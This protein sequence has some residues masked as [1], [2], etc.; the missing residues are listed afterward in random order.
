[1]NSVSNRA[2]CIREAAAGFVRHP[3]PERPRLAAR[4]CEARKRRL[5][6]LN[7]GFLDA[8]SSQGSN[9]RQAPES[10]SKLGL[11][12]RK[13]Q[14]QLTKTHKGRLSPSAGK[15][16]TVSLNFNGVGAQ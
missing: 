3:A 14:N 12:P 13:N 9:A 10:L 2:I 5:N 7:L 8:E 1:M 4:R 15:P 16:V 11:K 6:H